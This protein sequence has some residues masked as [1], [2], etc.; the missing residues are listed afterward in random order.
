M[1]VLNS[2]MTFSN[3]V[4]EAFIEPLRSVLIIDDQYPTWDEILND[5]LEEAAKDKALSLRSS[6][7]SWKVDPTGPIKV[8]NQF[9]S[10]KRGFVIDIHDHS[11]TKSADH[12]HQSDLLVLDY[13]LE[14]SQSGLGGTLARG[15]LQ[16][17][18]A[19]KHFNLVIVHTDEKSLDD[20]MFECLLS[21]M[22]SCTSQFGG[23]VDSDL[24]HLDEKLDI[25]ETEEKFSRNLLNEKFGVIEYLKLRHPSTDTKQIIRLFKNSEG[26]LGVL[27]AWGAEIGLNGRE[28]NTFYYWA[29]REFEKPKLEMFAQEAFEGL[30]WNSSKGCIWMRTVRGFVTFVAKGPNNLIETLQSALEN[31]K[32][33]PSRLISAKYRH[34]LSSVGVEA[35]DRTLQKKHVFAHFYKHFCSPVGLNLTN[36]EQDRLRIA[37]LKGYVSRQSEAISFLI[38]DEVINF[39]EKIRRIDNDTT[40][41]FGAHYGVDL[42]GE[43]NPE[44]SKAVAHYNSYVSTLPLKDGDDQ[45][46]SGHIFKWN[47]EWWVCATPACDLQ[48]GQNTTAFVGSSTTQRPFT[49]LK[50]LLITNLQTLTNDHINSGLFCFVEQTPGEVICLGLENVEASNSITNGKATWRTFIASEKGLIAN[51]QMQMIVP[52]FENDKLVLGDGTAE[53]IAKLRYEYALNYIQKVGSSV[54]RI[55]LGYVSEA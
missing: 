40:G 29:I 27:G 16:S 43:N 30:T 41:G 46:D 44:V 55:G 39:G 26:L 33:T 19:N 51:N 15:V 13:N 12:L 24:I 20:V 47:N 17:V 8:I 31:W 54:T 2:Q 11:D 48:P 14:G 35:E 10:Q 6:G 36:D 21:T 25:L 32:P 3:L 34:E 28:L 53:I 7:K 4:Q 37:K 38:E 23:R 49:A 9:R 50:L 22:T 42:T 5:Q 45:L 18:L 1:Q 52:K